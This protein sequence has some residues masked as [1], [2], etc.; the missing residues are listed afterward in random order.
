M[1][2]K[3]KIILDLCGGTGAWSNPY[4][5]AGY[6]VR[7]ITLP[8]Y[9]VSTYNPPDNVYGI[10]AAPPCLEFSLAR[11]GI[12]NHMTEAPKRDF[13]RGLVI[14]NHCL[15]IVSVSSPAFWALENPCGMLSR[16]LGKPAFT[17]QLWQFGD[18]WTKRTALWGAFN[19][20]KPLFK[21]QEDCLKQ[22]DP[23]PI[24][25]W[26]HPLGICFSLRP[27]K[28]LPSRA[29][30]DKTT[31]RFTGMKEERSA[32]RAITP[33]GFARAFFEANR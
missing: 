21:T 31:F 9:D 10:L 24:K 1:D 11:N 14:V 26:F 20:P 18:L 25:N 4:K 13:E 19:K 23:I 30:M 5:N 22:I 27:N 6:D 29:D 8:D 2:N 33:P 16:F 15:R 17:F 7:V 28:I 12:N 3:D 32:F